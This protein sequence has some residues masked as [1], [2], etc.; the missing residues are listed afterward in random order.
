MQY[1]IMAFG[2]YEAFM[3]N[4]RDKNKSIAHIHDQMIKTT[5]EHLPRH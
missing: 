5:L 2:K 3:H 4:K 1:N